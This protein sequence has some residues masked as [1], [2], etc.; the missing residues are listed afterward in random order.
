MHICKFHIHGVVFLTRQKQ[1]NKKNNPSQFL[2]T[3][4]WSRLRKLLWV[5][6]FEADTL[7]MSKEQQIWKSSDNKNSE[8]DWRQ[9]LIIPRKKNDKDKQAKKKRVPKHLTCEYPSPLG[10]CL[11]GRE[12]P[13]TLGRHCCLEGPGSMIRKLCSFF[14]LNLSG[15]RMT[16]KASSISSVRDTRDRLEMDP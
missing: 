2:S 4:L 10:W 9:F 7:K 12:Y 13:E 11:L 5:L 8:D 14:L 16:K 6:C 3:W 15:A 1:L